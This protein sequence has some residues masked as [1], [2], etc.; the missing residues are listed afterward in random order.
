MNAKHLCRGRSRQRCKEP[1]LSLL[2]VRQSALR[3]S[4]RNC[5]RRRAVPPR[6]RARS[7]RSSPAAIDTSKPCVNRMLRCPQPRLFVALLDIESTVR[8]YEKCLANFRYFSS[9]VQCYALVDLLICRDV[10]IYFTN[11]ISEN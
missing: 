3:S 4:A 8:C 6:R 11:Y 1:A 10:H 5:P 9:I 2:T 7:H